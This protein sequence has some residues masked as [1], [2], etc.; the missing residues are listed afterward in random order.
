MRYGFVCAF[1]LAL[2]TFVAGMQIN[3][4]MYNPVQDESYNEWIE[5]YNN[6]SSIDL[7]GWTLCGKELLPGYVNHSDGQTYYNN[8]SNLS[9]DSYA[10]ITDGGTGSTNG[11]LVL[12][13]FNVPVSTLFFHIDGT[14]MC[15]GGLTNTG[16]TITLN[17][18]DGTSMDNIT[19]S[20]SLG[21]NGNSK[22]LGKNSSNEWAETS[23]P[24]PGDNNTFSSNS[25]NPNNEYNL[26][27]NSFPTS[28]A[29]GAQS[30][31]N[32]TF[33]AGSY[34]FSK[35]KIVAYA[36]QTTSSGP[37]IA[38]DGTGSKISQQFFN[39][40]TAKEYSYVNMSQNIT[41]NLTF[42]LES[43]CNNADA[44]GVYTG[45]VRAYNLTNASANEWEEIQ[46]SDFSFSVSANQN[47]PALPPAAPP[48]SPSGGSNS[49]S[50]VSPSISVD[51]T[52]YLRI[53]EDFEIEAFIFNSFS[54]SKG[55][56]IYSYIYRSD[57]STEYANVG[58]PTANKQTIT[59]K[60]NSKTSVKLTN[61]IKPDAEGIYTLK[62]RV[63]DGDKNYD[64][65]ESIKLE[66]LPE[67]EA[68]VSVNV[69]HNETADNPT[70]SGLT[71]FF[72]GLDGN[73][74]GNYSNISGAI[75]G[76]VGNFISSIVS[77]I[78]NLISSVLANIGLRF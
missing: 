29:F 71:G 54:V 35:I 32:I 3:E 13:N 61:T 42:N 65:T 8:G 41:T 53:D 74:T 58:G 34:N 21:A 1:L 60:P 23:V 12:D 66:K 63:K 20:S 15:T 25:S 11:S 18:S 5:L 64:G 14:A 77:G 76:G 37:Y 73:K 50:T 62:V 22:T 6:E 4:I 19:Y 56:E 51:I 17:K 78:I 26:T 9:A 49:P 59:L 72:L 75:I 48:S 57:G 43:N 28:L 27:L 24:T 70:P 7:N 36:R 2:P 46:T 40:D 33:S 68:K 31:V 38:I 67:T 44:T 16:D 69:E 55:V 39:T 30:F 10:L 47:C 52:K 45:R